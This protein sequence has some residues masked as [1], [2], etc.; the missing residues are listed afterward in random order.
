MMAELVKKANKN[1]I[2]NIIIKSGCWIILGLINL[3]FI[4]L[5][6]LRSI[7][8][9]QA[10]YRKIKKLKN[11]YK[12]QRCFIICTGPSLT[13]QDLELLHNEYTFAMNSIV[14]LYDKTTFRPSFYGCIDE[15]VWIKL[16]DLIKKY[17]S[18]NILTFISNRQTKHDQLRKHWY[19]IPV[20][21]AYHTYDRWFKNKFWCK[22]SD[23]AYKG[24]YDLYS[25]THFLIQIA[26]YMGFKEIYLL[27]ADCNFPQNAPVHFVDY[28]VEDKSL[29]T[30][31]ERN[32]CGY[33]KVKEYCD[34]HNIKIYNATRGGALEIFDRVNLDDIISSNVQ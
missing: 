27:G 30:A 18:S 2:M 31:Q 10:K 32:I 3:K 16:R 22:I 21:V 17:D 7:G 11:K 4:I 8:I 20:N 6:W 14:L 29:N 24:V 19:E 5:S 33:K 26:I 28:G 9:A 15:G 13:T 12:D 1:W 25:V 23:D 34:N